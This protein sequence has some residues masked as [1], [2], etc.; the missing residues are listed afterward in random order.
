MLVLRAFT[1]VLLLRELSLVRCY[2]CRNR[3]IG[4]F[5]QFQMGVKRNTFMF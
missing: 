5:L 4:S 1:S 2:C 3:F